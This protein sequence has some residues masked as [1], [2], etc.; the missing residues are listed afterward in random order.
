MGWNRGLLSRANLAQ[1]AN[2]WFKL[3]ASIQMGSFRRFG[4]SNMPPQRGFIPADLVEDTA[5]EMSKLQKA[6]LVAKV[7]FHC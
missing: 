7:A 1:P 6:I 3:R 5:V 4:I 2:E